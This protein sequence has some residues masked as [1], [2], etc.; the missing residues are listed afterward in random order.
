MIYLTDIEFKESVRCL[1]QGLQINFKDVTLLVGN[2]GCGK[3]TLLELLSQNSKKIKM[4]ITEN[5]EKNGIGTFYFD[6][7]KMNPRI[8]NFNEYTNPDGTSKG[9]GVGG[10]ILSKFKSHGEVLVHFTVSQLNLAKNA[11]IFLDEPE[12]S[13]S[14]RNQIELIKSIKKA[15]K[16][17][18][19]IIATHCYPL[20]KSFDEV[21][22][23]ENKTWVNSNDYLKQF[24][25]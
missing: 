4:T 12:S 14:L 3:S 22:D 24:S 19:L 7:E 25:L 21:Y 5:T 8:R 17:C 10:A 15:S 11:V 13:L 20:I 2:Q 23:L 1:T 18:Q 6:T 9:I 16:T